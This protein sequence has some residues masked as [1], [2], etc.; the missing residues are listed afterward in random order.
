[1]VTAM[2][3]LSQVYGAEL[4]LLFWLACVAIYLGIGFFIK[5]NRTGNG[6]KRVWIGLLIA[7]V[8]IDL[9]WARIYYSNGTYRNYGI[10]AMYGLLLWIPLLAAT[11]AIVTVKNKKTNEKANSDFPN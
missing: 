6:F 4:W 3:S 11:L 10:G 5:E 8:L 7:E 9:L 2:Y 1:M